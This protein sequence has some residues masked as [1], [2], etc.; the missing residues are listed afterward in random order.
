MYYYA[1][2]CLKGLYMQLWVLTIVSNTGYKQCMYQRLRQRVKST[3]T[4]LTRHEMSGQSLISYG[5]AQYKFQI[6]I[7]DLSDK[8]YWV[9]SILHNR[10]RIFLATND[11][12]K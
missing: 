7:G 9:N 8:I 6:G 10:L 5:E 2:V 3:R 4:T 11:G 12:T 1:G